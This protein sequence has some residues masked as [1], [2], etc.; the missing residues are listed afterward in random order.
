MPALDRGQFSWYR[1]FSSPGHSGLSTRGVSQRSCFTS[2]YKIRLGAVTKTAHLPLSGTAACFSPKLDECSRQSDRGTISRSL[3]RVKGGAIKVTKLALTYPTRR[4]AH[5]GYSR[6]KRSSP[7]LLA[8][9]SARDRS[10]PI[11]PPPL[12]L[13]SHPQSRQYGR[14][15]TPTPRPDPRALVPG[16]PPA[17]ALHFVR[18]S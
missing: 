2:T 3:A 5:E 1:G 4:A 13:R 10:W 7:R 8:M 17:P 12:P 11:N 6:S 9:P 18:A 15:N 14:G 16:N